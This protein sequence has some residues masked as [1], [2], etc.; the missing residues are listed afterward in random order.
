VPPR[1]SRGGD[2]Q[3]I[4]PAYFQYVVRYELPLARITRRAQCFLSPDRPGA[5]AFLLE[6]P[7]FFGDAKT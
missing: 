7:A 1:R 2:D 4:A 3:R 5:I 6:L